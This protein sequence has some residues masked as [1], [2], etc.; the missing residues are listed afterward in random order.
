MY[1]IARVRSRLARRPDNDK[2]NII[3]NNYVK[4]KTK[5]NENAFLYGR[6]SRFVAQPILPNSSS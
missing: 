2:F 3:I 1:I 5:K 6:W 4:K